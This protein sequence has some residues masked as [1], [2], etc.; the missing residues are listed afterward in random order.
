MS[1]ASADLRCML[2]PMHM[3][4]LLLPNAA[5][6]EIIGYR[7]PEPGADAADGNLGRVRWRQ[8]ELPVVDFERLLGGEEQAPGIRQRIAVCYAPDSQGRWPLLGLLAQGIP[9]LLR[10]NQD[11]IEEATCGPHG[12]SPVRLRL[13][14]AGEPLTVP[15]LGY[16]QTQ[17]A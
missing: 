3:G 4:R 2:I 7:E 5:V 9:R 8:R 1:Q 10:L 17:L 15:D 6:A 14:V 13:T 12:E 11:V 16:L